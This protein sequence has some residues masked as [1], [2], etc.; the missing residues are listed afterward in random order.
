MSGKNA[1]LDSSTNRV[2]SDDD[3][4]QSAVVAAGSPSSNG[5]GHRDIAF[6]LRDEAEGPE[7]VQ[8]TGRAVAVETTGS[9]P[10]PAA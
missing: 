1:L 7:R 6:S 2:G 3:V 10:A 4:A 5:L 8:L 9:K